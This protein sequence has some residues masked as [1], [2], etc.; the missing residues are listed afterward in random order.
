[1]YV[2]KKKQ[3]KILMA[4]LSPIKYTDISSVKIKTRN[5]EGAVD[6]FVPK[7]QKRKKV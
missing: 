3:K 2:K 4:T 6:L 5:K 7:N 1:M